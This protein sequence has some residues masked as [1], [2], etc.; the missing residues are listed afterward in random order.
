MNTNMKIGIILLTTILLGGLA[1]CEVP[2]D[3]DVGTKGVDASFTDRAS[4]RTLEQGITA[5]I[6]V[7][8]KNTGASSAS[9][10]VRLGYNQD[11]LEVETSTHEFTSIPGKES[12]NRCQGQEERIR[13][14]VKPYPLP[15]VTQ[16]FEADLTL[17]ICYEYETNFSTTVCVDPRIQGINILDP[18]CV[19]AERTFSGGQGGPIGIVRVAAPVYQ[20]HDAGTV[21]IRFTVENFGNGRIVT[22]EEPGERE[23]S[24]SVSSDVSENYLF[25]RTF[26][27]DIRMECTELNPSFEGAPIAARDS[28]GEVALYKT[29]LRP[30]PE[31]I[32]TRDGMLTLRRFTF[33]CTASGID[34]EREIDMQVNTELRYFYRDTRSDSIT[35]ELRKI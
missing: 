33:V 4:I 28:N 3:C 24:C 34:L 25:V 16:R 20:D 32:E 19:P 22:Y 9:G 23:K 18:N 29:F 7:S 8:I 5:P 11:L 14:D 31:R 12:W 15:I 6:I 27:D 30:D 1:S 13:F 26:L 21:R 35:T 10:F 17:D 2:L